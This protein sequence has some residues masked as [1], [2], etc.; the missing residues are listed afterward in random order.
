[1]PIVVQRS[2]FDEASGYEYHVCFDRSGKCEED[3]VQLRV[4][5]EV[6]V[7]IGETGELA[8]FSF[9]IPKGFRSYEA[10][11]LIRGHANSQYVEPRVF[12]VFPGI[13]GD[14]VLLAS[15]RLEMDSSGRVIGI[16]INWSPEES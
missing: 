10:L 8:D 9:E 5:V 6:A 2:N 15:G 14:T 1:M 11:S 13:N 16:Q 12:V 4:P 7:S 3:R